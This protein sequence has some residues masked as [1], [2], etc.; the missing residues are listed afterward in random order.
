MEEFRE[1]I[2]VVGKDRIVYYR[3]IARL[4]WNHTSDQEKRL[5]LPLSRRGQGGGNGAEGRSANVDFNLALSLLKENKVPLAHI[6]DGT[7]GAHSEFSGFLEFRK[8]CQKEQ[9]LSRSLKKEW[10]RV[11]REFLKAGI[12]SM[13]IK[14]VGAFPYESSNLDVLIKQ[15]KRERAESILKE[16]GYIQLHNVEEPYKTLFRTFLAGEP[17]LAIHLHNKVAWINPFHDEDLLWARYRRSA[18]DELVDIPSSEDSILILTAHWFYEDK[19]IKLSDIMKISACLK[20]SDLDWEYMREVA[21]KKGWLNGFY[22]GLLVQSLIEKKLLGETSIDEGRL[23]SMR[24]ELSGWMRAYFNRKV[25]ATE[26]TLPFKLPKMF[27]K[28][29]HFVKTVRDKTTSPSRKIYEL[30][31]VAH[32]ALFSA[33]FYEFKINIRRQQPMLISISG[34]DGSGKTTYA[35]ALYDCLTF[36][37]LRTKLVWSRV[38]SSAFLKPFSK[39]AKILYGR[40]KGKRIPEY[41]PY[42][43]SEARRKHL[44]KESSVFRTLGISMLLLEMLGQYFWE[45]TVPLLLRK[46]VICDRYACD[47]LVDMATRYNLNTDSLEGRVF[48]K[49]LTALTRK[50]DVAYVLDLP[51]EEICDRREMGSEEK[52]LIREQI[53]LYKK[54][55]SMYKLHQIKNDRAID[56]ISDEMIREIL[57]EYYK[58]WEGVKTK[59]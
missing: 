52:S 7:E 26:S 43:E 18:T 55:S 41:E 5:M 49:V 37:E 6:N 38:G 36:C 45:V 9:I 14:S 58:K 50:P 27:G 48:S 24:A 25:D 29:L 53:D 4:S 12:E 31:Q 21:E 17:N 54:L 33:L 16:L 59:I 13:L 23:K 1:K 15:N 30:Y 35:K 10:T 28:F 3:F 34:V 32:G 20:K 57:T 11:R 56:K 19:K 46:V 8:E 42:Q 22:F 2:P 40:R 39:T 47:T 44:F 51:L